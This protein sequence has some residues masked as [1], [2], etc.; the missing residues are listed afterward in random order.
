MRRTAKLLIPASVLAL[1]FLS[2]APAVSASTL[3]V[4]LNPST[5]VATMMSTS[6]TSIIVTYPANSTL[7]GYLNG[8]AY[9]SSVSGAFPSG[10]QGIVA[11]EGHFRDG[12]RGG[13]SVR[14]MTVTSSYTASANS[15]TLV[16]SK[17]TQISATVSGVFKVV[18]GTVTADLGWRSFQVDGALDLPLQGHVFDVN[19]LGASVT[20][21]MG[22]RGLGVD[23]VVAMF[24]GGSLWNS[25]TLNFSSL[26][27]PLTNWTK[28][29]NSI[30]NTTTFSKTI[31]GQSS[32]STS[33]TNN[34]Q[35]YSLKE[36]SDPSAVIATPGYAVVSGNSLSIVAVPMYLSPIMWV[37]A[38]F[39][40]ALVIFA[41]VMVWRSRRHMPPPA[42]LAQPL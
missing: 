36:T 6:V 21:A 16:I 15:T 3:K 19:L 37:E 8:Y 42:P 1:L 38:G 4:E 30:T 18:N 28:S 17:Q 14:N 11:F 20:S 29:Y 23:A 27:T 32:L 35:T 5:G 2:M 13:I 24:G 12:D 31:S 10:S 7:S 25:P 26:N 39:L 22:G 41:G 40:G 34:G 9:N 33:Y